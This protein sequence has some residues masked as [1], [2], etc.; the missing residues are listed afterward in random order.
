MSSVARHLVEGGALD[1]H[2]TDHATALNLNVALIASG[3]PKAT[4]SVR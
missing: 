3:D 2:G 1:R 4:S